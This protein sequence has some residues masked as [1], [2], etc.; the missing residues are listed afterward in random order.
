M[1]LGGLAPGTAAMAFTL[2]DIASLLAAAALAIPVLLLPGHIL[3][4]ASNFL[5]FR[6]QTASRQIILALIVAYAVLPLADSMIARFANLHVALAFNLALALLAIAQSGRGLMPALPRHTWMWL[7]AAFGLLAFFWVDLAFDGRLYPSL[8]AGDN[9]KHAATVRALVEGGSAPPLDPFF[10]RDQP[11]GYY[12]FYYTP[13]ALIEVLS[14]GLVDSRA[15]VGGHL[16]W[17]AIAM[18]GLVVVLIE[19]SGFLPVAQRAP[20]SLVVA[21]MAAGGLQM[22]IALPMILALGFPWA[23]QFDWYTDQMTSW[24]LSLLWVPHHI[25]AVIASWAGFLALSEARNRPAGATTVLVALAG[26]AFAS[27]AGLS[28]WVTL[29]AVMTVGLW[30]GWLAARREWRWIGLMALA[31]TIALVLALPHLSDVA[32]FRS[33]GDFPIALRVRSLIYAEMISDALGGQH[34]W[35]FRLIALPFTYFLLGGLG[36][37]GSVIFWR[38]RGVSLPHPS[39]TARLITASALGGLIVGSLFASTISLNDLGWRVVLFFQLAAVVWTTALLLPVWRRIEAGSL[40]TALPRFMPKEVLALFVAGY[41][42]VAH[43]LVGIRAHAA[44]SMWTDQ[45][46][47]DARVDHDLRRAYG[48]LAASLDANRVV[49]HNPD[50]MRAFGYGLY[51][52][53]RTAISDKH[54][55]I[56]F[57]PSKAEAHARLDLIRPIFAG[58][59]SAAEARRVLM[60]H[61]IDA[62]V[63]SLLDPVWVAKA[64]WVFATPALFETATVRVLSVAAL[65]D[66]LEVLSEPKASAD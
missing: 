11:A 52:R 61:H 1:L 65:R 51:G 53:Q 12:Y 21:I 14:F 50:R 43:E 39:E 63:V 33:Y 48:A 29:G 20:V 42:G 30:T 44:L 56:L 47:T 37:I 32:R 19:R 49:Q 22:L 9:V 5:G 54:N 34:S 24:P 46:T 2:Y 55:A 6:G 4:H 10:L 35:L 15:A 26:A 64:A 31:G 3:A 28:T 16:F 36:F 18:V 25:A 66:Q 62:V 38:R 8:L 59:L 23:A 58:V 7:A 41:L 57:G 60:A 17:T 40:R 45:G 13:S 27:A